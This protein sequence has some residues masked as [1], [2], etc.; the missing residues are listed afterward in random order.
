MIQKL[1]DIDS[2]ISVLSLI[3]NIFNNCSGLFVC[4]YCIANRFLAD[5]YAIYLGR[6]RLTKSFA[7]R[8]S[9]MAFALRLSHVLLHG[10]EHGVAATK[11]HTIH[12]CC[13]DW[14]FVDIVVSLLLPVRDVPVVT[15]L[16]GSFF[17]QIPV[18]HAISEGRLVVRGPLPSLFR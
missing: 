11:P 17:R 5:C 8:R 10:G 2:K 14:A 18:T 9:D 7:V 4:V 12:C 13:S 3:N 6:S 15:L 16:L 1:L